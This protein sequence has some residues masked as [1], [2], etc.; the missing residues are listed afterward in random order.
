MNHLSLQQNSLSDETAKVLSDQLCKRS[1]SI[2]HLDLSYN[3][4]N[5][6]GGELL[7]KSLS[8]NISLSYLNLKRNNL[9]ETTGHIMA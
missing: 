5:N 3:K 7:A 2:K 1:Q 9:K 4:I 6:A 8:Q